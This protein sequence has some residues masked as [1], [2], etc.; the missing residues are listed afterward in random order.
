[1][2]NLD[3][4]CDKIVAYC[5]CQK[6]LKLCGSDKNYSRILVNI[7]TTVRDGQPQAQRKGLMVLLFSI[8]M[9]LNFKC[10][11]SKISMCYGGLSGAKNSSNVVLER[12]GHVSCCS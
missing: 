12:H 9:C 11:R 6:E 1:M 7:S 3:V 5:L 4:N 8:V 10:T 2:T